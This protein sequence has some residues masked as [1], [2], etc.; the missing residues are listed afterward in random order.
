MLADG[1]AGRV[2]DRAGFFA[3]VTVQKFTEWA[4]ADEADAG[5]VLFLR[6]GQADVFGNA[7]HFGFVQLAHWEQGLGQLRLVQAVQKVALV[8]GGVQAFEQF[9]AAR[10]FIEPNAAVVAGGDLFCPQAHGVV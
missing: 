1:A 10:L 6:V 8:F 5:G 9:V 7:A 3:D 2:L 4:L